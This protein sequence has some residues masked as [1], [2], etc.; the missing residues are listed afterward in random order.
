MASN[1]A[2]SNADV[3]S[4]LV[5]VGG[6]GR[7]SKESLRSLSPNLT[8]FPAVVIITSAKEKR[9]KNKFSPSCRFGPCLLQDGKCVSLLNLQPARGN[10]DA[11]FPNLVVA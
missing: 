6:D 5:A 9:G 4:I 2:N 11:S 10:T 8:N 1:V 7:V 3:I